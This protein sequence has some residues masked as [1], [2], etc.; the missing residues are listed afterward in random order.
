MPTLKGT[1]VSLSSVQ[2]FLY[3]VS[4]INVSIFHSTWPDTFW[5]DRVCVC[6][7]VCMRVRATVVQLL[8][9]LWGR[10]YLS[11][12]VLCFLRPGSHPGCW[13]THWWMAPA[14]FNFVLAYQLAVLRFSNTFLGLWGKDL[15]T[16]FD[17]FSYI[18]ATQ[19]KKLKQ[20][21]KVGG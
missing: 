9:T 18:R 2:C 15:P 11:S 5:T 13:L 7:C 20:V 6:V 14:S 17:C 8:W 3:L 4:S 10:F 16:Q 19:A 12:G 1:E 21:W